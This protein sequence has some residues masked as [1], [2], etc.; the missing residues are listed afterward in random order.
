MIHKHQQNNVSSV[1]SMGINPPMVF[2]LFFSPV[3][4]VDSFVSF[5]PQLNQDLLI[6]KQIEIFHPSSLNLNINEML[7][8]MSSSVVLFC[9]SLKAFFL[10]LN[11]R[12]G[13]GRHAQHKQRP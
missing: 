5:I 2:P 13:E 4:K 9:E 12:H 3:L 8:D 1:N 11:L 6:S 10:F 7:A